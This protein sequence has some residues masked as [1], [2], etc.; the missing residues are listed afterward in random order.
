MFTMLN[1]GEKLLTKLNI[2]AVLRFLAITLVFLIVA[3]FTAAAKEAS[4]V[5][6]ERKI[7]IYGMSPEELKS[8]EYIPEN[9][10]DVGS[11]TS[12]IITALHQAGYVSAEGFV[13]SD[14]EIFLNQGAITVVQVFGV[15]G[16]AEE[17][18]NRIARQLIGKR[19]NIDELDETLAHINALSGVD[20]TFA[21]EAS[22]NRIM[23]PRG[24]T[25]EDNTSHYTLI[26]KATEQAQ[27]Y[28]AISVDSSPRNLFERN[29]ATITQTVNSVLVGGDHIQGSF[30]HIWGDSQDDQNEGS[31][32]YFVPLMDNG[33][34]AELFGSYSVS[35]SQVSPNVKRDFQGT[36]ITGI[37]GYPIFR[38]H[39]ETLTI[40][41]GIGYQG[42]D[43]EGQSNAH[44]KAATSPLFYNHSDPEGNSITSGITVT[45]GNAT[46]QSNTRE[47]GA[48]SHLRAGAGYIH[49]LSFLGDDTELRLEGFGQLTGDIVP[50]GQ[51]FILGGT[52]FLR[53]YPSGVYSGNNGA[54]GT[55]EVGHKYFFEN[56]YVT[57]MSVKAF[58]DFGFVSNTA[59]DAT[60]DNRPEQ[61]TIS[62]IGLAYSADLAYGLGLSGWLGA[63]LNKGNQ[64]ENLGPAVY[65]K[66]TKGW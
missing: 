61:K 56:N 27:Q 1:W 52:E 19:P 22:K 32:T 29:R 25:P 4:L 48:F 49:S 20:A 53:G 23:D 38:S 28:G 24:W 50:S 45:A 34:Y 55:L 51:K 12:G 58:W 10:A 17:A 41:G 65:L 7:T 59:A 66:L 9:G 15:S 54:A 63:P 36:T 43:L 44:A 64:G 18:A 6:S 40:L 39:D 35:K 14:T 42:E 5:S 33:L 8:I 30:T 31:A 47:N 13:I 37:I 2:K 60:S 57:G 21:L 3:P 11:I 62:S 16:K 46:S 26:V